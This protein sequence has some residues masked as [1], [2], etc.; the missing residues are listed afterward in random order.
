MYNLYQQECKD[1][2]HHHQIIVPD[3][4][5][6]MAQTSRINVIN[7]LVLEYILVSVI[8]RGITLDRTGTVGAVLFLIL[9]AASNDF[10]SNSARSAA[11]LGFRFNV[12]CFGGGA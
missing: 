11:D 6:C 9:L 5:Q 1:I 10:C 3:S 12:K 7:A 2:S 8:L 4:T